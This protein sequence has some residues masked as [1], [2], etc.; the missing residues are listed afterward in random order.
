MKRQINIDYI[1]VVRRDSNDYLYEE[2]DIIANQEIIGKLQAITEDD[3]KSILDMQACMRE[4]FG[5]EPKPVRRVVLPE[6]YDTPFVF[7]AKYPDFISEEHYENE[8]QKVAESVCEEDAPEEFKEYNRECKERFSAATLRYIHATAF[9]DAEAELKSDESVILHSHEELGYKCW[10]HSPSEDIEIVL[11]TNFGMGASSY[12][13]LDIKYKGRKLV[14]YSPLVQHYT[15]DALALS[16]NTYTFIAERDNWS[17]LLRLVGDLCQHAQLNSSDLVEKWV[18]GDVDTLI[19][20][21]KEI[22]ADPAGMLGEMHDNPTTMFSGHRISNMLQK[23]C[24]MFER[25]SV[26]SAELFKANKLTEALSFVESLRAWA[27]I[28]PPATEVA[29]YIEEQCR[30]T[31]E[32]LPTLIAR[33][34]QKIDKLNERLDP[35]TASWRDIEERLDE[36][37][38]D[39]ETLISK[40]RLDEKIDT[41]LNEIVARDGF[42]KTLQQCYA[43]IAK[44]GILLLRKFNA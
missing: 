14:S 18:K 34:Q 8:C 44:S 41:L 31:M 26:E 11:N 40:G 7:P 16:I 2:H 9:A 28:Y 19:S 27:D 24:D 30:L 4:M 43:K 39:A 17:T 10:K 37:P 32:E 25:Y 33:Q 3:T 1:G 38:E 35:L 21:L 42:M 6:N 23:D 15:A 22:V 5:D 20:G 13:T 36:D 29:K 12:I